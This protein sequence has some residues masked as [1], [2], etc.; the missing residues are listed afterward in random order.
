MTTIN[1][2]IDDS[3]K[4]KANKTL[5]ELGI[6]MS[7]AIKIFLNQVVV[8]EA[9]PFTPSTKRMTIRSEWDKQVID[10]LKTKG[11]K[12]AKDALKI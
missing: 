5:S 8:E 6:D 2:R 4:K 11:Y 10:A 9:L 1:V 3:L 7:T 12:K